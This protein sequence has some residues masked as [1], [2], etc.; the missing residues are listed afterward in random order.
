MNS[1][2]IFNNLRVV[3]DHDYIIDMIEEIKAASNNSEEELSSLLNKDKSQVE[4][5][6]KVDAL[7]FFE[8]ILPISVINNDIEFAYSLI[9]DTSISLEEFKEAIANN[10]ED[11]IFKFKEGLKELII[12]DNSIVVDSN[13][14]YLDV[15]ELKDDKSKIHEIVINASAKNYSSI[16]ADLYTRI[17]EDKVPFK[18]DVRLPIDLKKG[19]MDPIKISVSSLYFDRM[20]SIVSDITYDHKDEILPPSCIVESIEGGLY[21]YAPYDVEKDVRPINIVLDVINKTID[22]TIKDFVDTHPNVLRVVNNKWKNKMDNL[23]VIR[24]D[25]PDI[26][27]NMINNILTYLEQYDIDLTNL[28]TIPRLTLYSSDLDLLNNFVSTL[29]NEVEN[30]E[31]PVNEVDNNITQETPTEEPTHSINDLITNEVAID[32]TIPEAWID[33]SHPQEDVNWETQPVEEETVEPIPQEIVD[34]MVKEDEKVNQANTFDVN[35]PV[36]GEAPI[37]PVDE[38]APTP[39][40]E[41]VGNPVEPTLDTATEEVEPIPQEI[42]NEMVKQDEQMDQTQILNVNYPVFGE[43]PVEPIDEPA[44]TP[45]VEVVG[46]P[47]EPTLDVADEEQDEKVFNTGAYPVTDIQTKPLDDITPSEAESI[48]NA[49]QRGETQSA[50]EMAETLGIF[51]DVIS[52]EDALTDI[53]NEEG[54]T[55]TIIDYLKKHNAEE[56]LNKIVNSDVQDNMPGKDFL[57]VVIIPMLKEGYQYNDIITMHSEGMEDIAPAKKEGFFSKLF[58]SKKK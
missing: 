53:T 14:I 36:F 7:H 40:V 13:Q 16:L 32:S 15:E 44:P 51:K 28:Y 45:V 48:A 29:P 39:V 21:G 5:L 31:Q 9:K 52:V 18:M 49:P 24:T 27:E 35:Y 17:I 25:Y 23:D 6:N 8:G 58:K 1:Q 34:E 22:E 54:E 19:Y 38:P 50:P 26:F 55:V 11:V 37:K 3:V 42:V 46:N 57:S 41:V 33:P 4:E 43:A 10:N 47:V 12:K 20:L 2:E 30:I 56:L